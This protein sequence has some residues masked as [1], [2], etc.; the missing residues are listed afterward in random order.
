MS[1]RYHAVLEATELGLTDW[2]RNR[3]DGSVEIECQG[4]TQA[5][6]G[7][8]AWAESGPRYA[9]VESVVVSDRAVVDG[10]RGFVVRR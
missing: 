8:L 7:F 10:E 3:R 1:F 6:G 4:E 2:V 9:G 5:V